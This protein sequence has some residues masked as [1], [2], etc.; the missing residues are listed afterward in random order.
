MP[1]HKPS[2]TAKDQ[3]AFV[4]KRLARRIVLGKSED[5][6]DRAIRRVRARLA[7]ANIEVLR[8]MLRWATAHRLRVG[9][10]A[11]ALET[12]Q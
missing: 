7:K 2:R 10:P 8:A 3:I 4:R 12:R 9:L 1:S 11:R 5:G 6:N